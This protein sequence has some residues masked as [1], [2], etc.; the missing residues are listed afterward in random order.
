MLHS[1]WL[2]LSFAD[3]NSSQ[4]QNALGFIIVAL[5]LPFLIIKSIT[6]SVPYSFIFLIPL[7]GNEV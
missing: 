4:S 6:L 7:E 1:F 3:D 2:L 5:S